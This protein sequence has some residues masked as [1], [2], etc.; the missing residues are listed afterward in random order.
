MDKLAPRDLLELP[1]LEETTANEAGS[2][3]EPSDPAPGESEV[4]EEPAPLET[5][6]QTPAEEQDQQET[7]A[8]LEQ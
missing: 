5:D 8:S 6:V 7:H 2:D 3:D 4:Q 1:E